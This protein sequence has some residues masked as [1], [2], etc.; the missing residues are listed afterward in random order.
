[1]SQITQW[2]DFR[3]KS[4]GKI[5]SLLKLSIPDSLQKKFQDEEETSA[6]FLL[7]SKGI[8]NQ[9][10]GKGIH[11]LE[12]VRLESIRKEIVLYSKELNDRLKNFLNSSDNEKNLDDCSSVMRNEDQGFSISC[13]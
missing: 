1:M 7:D 6:R 8:E 10:T 13:E 5:S 3:L 2:N 4:F 12:I 9:S 11:V